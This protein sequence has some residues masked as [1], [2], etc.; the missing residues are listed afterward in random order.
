MWHRFTT[1]GPV[2]PCS[3][4]ALGCSGNGVCSGLTCVCNSGFFGPDCSLSVCQQCDHGSCV[5]NSCQC[6]DGQYDT[7]TTSS[8]YHVQD[9]LGLFVMLLQLVK[10]CTNYSPS[11]NPHYL[12]VLVTQLAMTETR[13]R[14][15]VLQPTCEHG[16]DR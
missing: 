11:H 1:H 14:Y 8:S 5:D 6:E 15:G 2:T 9:G 12:L 10:H 7:L 4:S 13:T 16:A 3:S